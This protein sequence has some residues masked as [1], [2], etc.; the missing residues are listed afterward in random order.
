VGKREDNFLVEKLER[1]R[2]L[3]RAKH[4]W[5]NNIKWNLFKKCR[6]N[7]YGLDSSGSG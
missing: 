7:V 1:K 6:R 2:P 3:G 5:K 4:R